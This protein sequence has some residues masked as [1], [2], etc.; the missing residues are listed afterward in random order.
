LPLRD[1]RMHEIGLR[2]LIRKIQ[3]IGAQ[4]DKALFPIFSYSKDHYFRVFLRCDKSK[5][6]VD[7]VIK[8]HGDFFGAGPMW[9]GKLWDEKLVEIME[10]N[11]DINDNKK[12]LNIIKEESKIDGVGFYDI[13]ELA[14]KYK[15]NKLPKIVDLSD[16][17]RKKSYLVSETHFRD[18]SIRTNISEDK[19]V[20]ILKS[21]NK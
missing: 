18:N 19:L 21:M 5:E 10:K 9:I 2:I 6:A 8:Q 17:I 20:W 12:I 7:S 16:E 14:S 11:N 15:I 4:F 3:L 1:Y 13:N